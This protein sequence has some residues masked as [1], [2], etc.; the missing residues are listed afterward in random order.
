M[1]HSRQD[2]LQHTTDLLYF[3]HFNFEHL[4]LFDVCFFPFCFHRERLEK[5][6]M[7]IRGVAGAAQSGSNVKQ[8]HDTLNKGIQ[9]KDP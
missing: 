5:K 2:Q 7:S 3:P 6:R 8:A 4:F 1:N 9:A